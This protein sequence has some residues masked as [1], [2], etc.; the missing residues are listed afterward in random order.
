MRKVIVLSML[1]LLMFAFIGCDNTTMIGDNYNPAKPV[2]QPHLYWKDIDVVVTDIDHNHWYA[3]YVH[4]YKTEVTV[5]S[6]EYNLTETLTEEASGMFNNMKH[7]STQKGDVIKVKLY[8]WMY[9]STGLIH[10]REIHGFS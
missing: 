5:Y 4:H 9:D 7:W 10:K 8:T 6:E 1:V 2:E 3:G